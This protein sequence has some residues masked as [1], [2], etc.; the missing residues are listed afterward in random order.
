VPEQ[1]AVPAM[2]ARP[3]DRF[4]A[5]TSIGQELCDNE[6]VKVMYVRHIAGGLR[7]RR[8]FGGALLTRLGVNA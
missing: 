8:G 5:E 3:V 4:V 2:C 1:F 6:R 7:L